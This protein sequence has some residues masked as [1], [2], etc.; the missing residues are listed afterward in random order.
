MKIQTFEVKVA[1]P[2][3]CKEISVDDLFEVF[4]QTGDERIDLHECAW[5]V[6]ETVI[7]THESKEK[8]K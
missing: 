7:S 6:E 3:Y 2:D 5:E 8:K 1:V 4:R